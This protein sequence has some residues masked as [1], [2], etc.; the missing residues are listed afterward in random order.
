MPVASLWTCHLESLLYKMNSG[1]SV[2]TCLIYL[3]LFHLPFLHRERKKEQPWMWENGWCLQV[4]EHP[5]VRHPAWRMQ[6]SEETLLPSLAQHRASTATRDSPRHGGL[7]NKSRCSLRSH[8]SFWVHE[9]MNWM[10]RFLLE[11][12]PYHLELELTN[13]RQALPFLGLSLCSCNY[14]NGC[15]P[16]PNLAGG[17]V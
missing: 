13:S 12:W 9:V 5:R 2:Y 16:Q 3:F 6:E 10:R 11:V 17:R 7:F 14:W 8:G 4:S 1:S 15:S